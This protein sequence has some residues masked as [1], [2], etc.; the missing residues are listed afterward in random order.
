MRLMTLNIW[1]EQGP[2]RARL[3]AIVRQVGQLAPDVLCLQEVRDVAP[4][5]PNQAETLARAL[6][7]HDVF[8]VAHRWGGGAEGLA[9]LTRSEPRRAREMELPWRE[10]GIRRISLGVELP[11]ESGARLWVFTTHLA[12]RLEEGSVRQRQVLGLDRFIRETSRGA[13]C[14]VAGDFNAAPET[15]EMRFMRGE[16]ALQGRR[17]IYRDAYASC[18]PGEAGWTWCSENPYTEALSWLPR[19]RRLDYL[20]I[21]DST[22]QQRARVRDCQVVCREPESDGVRCSDHYGVL[23]ELD[24]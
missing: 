22:A 10:T 7:M 8:A 19:D 6:D 24:F 4:R 20:F 9:I 5:V 13:P 23:A 17:T 12:H 21:R 16:T 18:H 15:E 2:W 3:Q 14:V 1:Q 11:L